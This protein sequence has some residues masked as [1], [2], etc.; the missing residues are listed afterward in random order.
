[1]PG[2]CRA[3]DVLREEAIVL[4]GMCAKRQF[5]VKCADTVV[6]VLIKSK[7][8]RTTTGIVF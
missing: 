7:R 3:E 2:I 5:L 8:S 4:R 6:L 1:M